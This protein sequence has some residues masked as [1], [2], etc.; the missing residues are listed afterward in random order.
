MSAGYAR[1]FR[2]WDEV[3]KTYDEVAVAKAACVVKQREDG[4]LKLRIIID[5]L[6]ACLNE[7]VKRE[8]RCVLPRLKDF[9]LDVLDLLD[10]AQSK[11]EEVRMLIADVE[12]AFHT[13]GIRRDERKFQIVRGL[14]GEFIGYETV[15][16]G[17]GASPGVWGRGASYLGRSGQSLF[18]EKELRV[19]VFVDDPAIAAR[20]ANEN[21][22]S[23]RMIVL[24]LCM[25]NENPNVS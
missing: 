24:L 7:F 8:E 16:F 20:G 13:L 18:D 1:R 6:R 21:E 11:G 22:C 3:V 23:R 15:L 14:D 4:T 10:E 17:G 5:W 2:S 9:V 12:D 19:E 25:E